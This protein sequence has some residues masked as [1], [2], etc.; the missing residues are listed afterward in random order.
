MSTSRNCSPG[1]HRPLSY[2]GSAM[3]IQKR[4][5]S[6]KLVSKYVRMKRICIHIRDSNECYR[7]FIFSSPQAGKH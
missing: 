3:Q 7:K 4:S 5:N 6:Q 2:L 1:F